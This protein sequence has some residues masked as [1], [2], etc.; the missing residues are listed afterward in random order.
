MSL[1]V[2]GQ[3]TTTGGVGFFGQLKRLLVVLAFFP[4]DRELQQ[5]ADPHRALL[6]GLTGDGFQLLQCGIVFWETT[7]VDQGC[8]ATGRVD[9]LHLLKAV[10]GLI[11]PAQL[12]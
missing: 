1:W 12:H 6:P 9:G 5:Q 7:R 4:G 8:M 10:Y 3:Q 11:K 2:I